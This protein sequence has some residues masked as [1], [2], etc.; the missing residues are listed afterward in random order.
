MLLISILKNFRH[1]ISHYTQQLSKD[2]SKNLKELHEL[3][4][5]SSQIDQVYNKL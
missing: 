4:P 2:T 3:R 5:Y 1:Q